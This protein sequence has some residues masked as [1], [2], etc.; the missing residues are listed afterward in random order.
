M[1]WLLR[2]HHEFVVEG[3]MRLWLKARPAPWCDAAGH[4]SRQQLRTCHPAQLVSTRSRPALLLSCRVREAMRAAKAQQQAEQQ[5]Q[6]GSGGEEDGDDFGSH[7][8]RKLEEKRKAMGIEQPA[9]AAAQQQEQQRH[10]T[11]GDEPELDYGE[12]SEE[13]EE[14][15]EEEGECIL[16]SSDRPWGRRL[17]GQAPLGAATLAGGR[18]VPAG[19]DCT[20]GMSPCCVNLPAPAPCPP[21][22]PCCS[23]AQAVAPGGAGPR[24]QVVRRCG[25][26]QQA[27]Q[28][29]GLRA[30]H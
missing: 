8:R 5:Q 24:P 17:V 20:S 22:A 10:R 1:S 14:E 19:A 12:G 2:A 23:P 4:A 7:M 21:P 11:G 13:G 9:A 18:L 28:G 30:A 26:A 29:G 25:C 15:E 6:A 3:A 16:R 27:D